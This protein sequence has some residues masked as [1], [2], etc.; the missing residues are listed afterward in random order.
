MD[1]PRYTFSAYLASR[2][3]AIAIAAACFAV[4]TWVMFATGQTVSA[5]GLVIAVL[6]VG[7]LLAFALDYR[8]TR[9]FYN[10]LAT[11]SADPENARVFAALIDEPRGR[12]RRA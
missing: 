6:I 5:V 3:Q 9:D 8:R 1:A 12:F 10:R 2:K 4:V 7:L 11:F